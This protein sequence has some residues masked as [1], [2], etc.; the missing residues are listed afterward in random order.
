VDLQQ[1]QKDKHAAGDCSPEA[2]EKP[3]EGLCFEEILSRLQH[4]VEELEEGNLPLEKALESFE[5][6]IRLARVGSR[7]LDEAE[8]RVEILLSD[9]EGVQNYPLDKEP[10]SK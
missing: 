2:A 5:Q 7:R 6:G 4:V 9:Q 10:E 3:L 8:R 1:A